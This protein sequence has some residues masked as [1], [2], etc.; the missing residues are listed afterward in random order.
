VNGWLC[1][2]KRFQRFTGLAVRRGGQDDSSRSEADTRYFSE[3]AIE[4]ALEPKE[5]IL[6]EGASHIDLYDKERNSLSGRRWRKW[7]GASSTTCNAAGTKKRRPRW[8]NADQLSELN[9]QSNED[10]L[11]ERA[12][13][14]RHRPNKH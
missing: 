13:S 14:R 7:W 11:W 1:R 10:Q 5:L 12:C 9:A 2:S 3:L 6:I 4:K 8:A